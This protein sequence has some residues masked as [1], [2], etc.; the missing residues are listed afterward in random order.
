[1][2]AV[3]EQGERDFECQLTRLKYYFHTYIKKGQNKQLKMSTAAADTTQTIS[4]SA[5]A[6]FEV[7]VAALLGP[8]DAAGERQPALIHQ[9]ALSVVLIIA[10]MIVYSLVQYFITRIQG[11]SAGSPWIVP[12][13]KDASRGM[14][15][16]QDPTQKNSILLR[17]SL[18]EANGIEFTY[19]TWIF[20]TD[21]ESN[22]G[23][24]KDIFYKG[25]FNGN[26]GTR[27]PGVYL[28]PTE[29]T[30]IVYMSTY[31]DPNSNSVSVPNIPVGKWFHLAITLKE[32]DVDIYINGLLK[33]RM[34]LNS[35]PKQ[36]FGPLVLNDNGGFEG[37]LSKFRY[38]D[39][40]VSNSEIEA[41]VSYGPSLTLPA[42]TMQQPPY[43][44]SSW[45]L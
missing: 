6:I 7:V 18:N 29:N 5:F 8:L 22:Y 20:I 9:L 21:Y 43:L 40:K 35:L 27:T 39:Y 3:G 32:H 1:V 23:R 25:N 41:A 16:S 13:I 24:P 4:T 15:I 26:F 36:N 37:Y 34:V 10:L 28:H 38:F 44:A 19:M 11:S 33:K 31:A 12:D 17:R 45:W 30:L 42:S 2:V 14:T